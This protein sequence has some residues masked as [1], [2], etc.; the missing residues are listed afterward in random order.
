G[1]RARGGPHGGRDGLARRRAGG[2]QARRLP[3]HCAKQLPVGEGAAG[4][5]ADGGGVRV[6]AGGGVKEV[7]QAR[8]GVCGRRGT[9]GEQALPLGGGHGPD[10]CQRGVGACGHVREGAVQG[11]GEGGGVACGKHGG[12]V[13]EGE[14]RAGCPPLHVQDR[15]VGGAPAVAFANGELQVPGG[16]SGRDELVVGAERD[17]HQGATGTVAAHAE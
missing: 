2:G 15:V 1:N 14:H 6:A 9:V 10:R 4:G 17:L 11:G 5:L 13:L 12:G 8:R 16:E 7:P 3:F